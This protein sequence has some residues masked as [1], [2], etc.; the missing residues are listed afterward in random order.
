MA[1]RKVKK[2][3]KVKTLEKWRRPGTAGA[4]QGPSQFAKRN[5]LKI[6]DVVAYLKGRDGYTLHKQG[7]RRFKRRKTVVGGINQQWIGDLLDLQKLSNENDDMKY[8][9]FYIDAISR[10]IYGEPTTSKSAESVLAATKTIFKRTKIKP[11]KIQFDRGGEIQNNKVR[12]YFSD[13]NIHLFFTEDDV[14]KASLIERC[15]RNFKR[16]IHAYLTE[17]H[18]RRY[19]DVLQKIIDSY[20]NTYH[21]GIG[22]TP[23]EVNEKNVMQAIYHNVKVPPYNDKVAFAI[24]EYV[25]ILGKKNTFDRGYDVL[26][27]EQI[28]Q[29][30]S[31]LRTVPITYQVNDLKGDAVDGS[32]YKEE[33]QS[34]DYPE[35][36]FIEKELERRTRIDERSN[37]PIKEVLVRWLGYPNK[38]DTWLPENQVKNLAKIQSSRK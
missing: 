30:K 3:K 18:T 7:K 29:I 16:I 14:N 17:Y 37:K 5:K 12:K 35:E 27:T 19:I 22:M 6:K 11:D 33:L 26:W 13:N 24:G 4:L 8:V 32:F 34:V 9:L 23:N 31:I 20:N 21:T 2:T 1:R 38:F 28:Y 25:R 36:F 10:K 15:N